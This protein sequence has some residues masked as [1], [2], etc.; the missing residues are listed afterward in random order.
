[1]AKPST[2]VQLRNALKEI[3]QLKAELA[4]QAEATQE[5]DHFVRVMC[6]DMALI[7]LNEAFGFGEERL[8]RFADAYAATWE[9]WATATNNDAKDDKFAEYSRVRYEEL[10]QRICGRYYVPDKERYL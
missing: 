4:Q 7:A 2:Y 6:Q 5:R 1:M 9:K 3:E 10:L 8:K